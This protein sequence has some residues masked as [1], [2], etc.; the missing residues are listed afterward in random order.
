MLR[1]PV[2]LFPCLVFY[3]LRNDAMESIA[4]ADNIHDAHVA[5]FGFGGDVFLEPGSQRLAEEVSAHGEADRKGDQQETP[6]VG[7]RS[8]HGNK[9][10]R[11]RQKRGR[12]NIGAASLVDGESA[13]AGAQSL[14]GFIR[15]FLNVFL[16]EVA[17]QEEAGRVGMSTHGLIFE[18][19]G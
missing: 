15:R 6:K 14:H 10:Q 8:R 16:R 12:R 3:L 1:V 7:P 9:R 19:T 17:H 5:E 2:Y 18:F 4:H 13:F 11:R